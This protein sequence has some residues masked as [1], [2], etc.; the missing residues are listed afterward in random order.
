MA[1]QLNIIE[2]SSQYDEMDVIMSQLDTNVY[3]VG[4]NGELLAMP[5]ELD[6]M[7]EI[8]SQIDTECM[9][10]RTKKTI[11]IKEIGCCLRTVYSKV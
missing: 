2:S 5:D 7:D 4:E 9:N 6:E 8:M 1:E 10:R 3:V 11:Y